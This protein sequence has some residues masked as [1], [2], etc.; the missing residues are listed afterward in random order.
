[1][2][3]RTSSDQNWANNNQAY[4]ILLPT[5]GGT[6]TAL[7]YYQQ[8]TIEVTWNGPFT[9]L[10][11]LSFTRIGNVVV[12]KLEGFV[13]PSTATAIFTSV[14]SV[15]LR[16][17]PSQQQFLCILGEN[18]AAQSV[19]VLRVDTNGDIAI[20]NVNA[21]GFTNGSGNCGPRGCTVCYQL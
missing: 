19:L 1:M 14:G 5:V 21:T 2:T 20:T 9:T 4:S 6:P 12:I 11:D 10:A 17:R 3:E 16:Y 15:P 18:A 7:N 8:E 13:N